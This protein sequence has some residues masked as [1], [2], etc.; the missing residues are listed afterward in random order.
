MTNDNISINNELV[1][2]KKEK[3][4]TTHLLLI[5]YTA[6]LGMCKGLVRNLEAWVLGFF[7]VKIIYY[8]DTL[9]KTHDEGNVA[10]TGASILDNFE[11]QGC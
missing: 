9:F 3:R 8:F 5:V 7:S 1:D 10:K 4:K 6:V 2:P 11:M